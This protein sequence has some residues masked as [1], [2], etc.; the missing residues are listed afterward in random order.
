MKINF[1]TLTPKKKTIVLSI[2]ISLLSLMLLLGLA[3]ASGFDFKDCLQTEQKIVV[4]ENTNVSADESEL[5]ERCINKC[6]KLGNKL[7]VCKK[8]AK[9]YQERLPAN[10][11]ED[12]STLPEEDFLYGECLGAQLLISD[13]R[14]MDDASDVCDQ[15]CFEFQKESKALPLEAI[16]DRCKKLKKEIFQD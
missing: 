15:K 10:V 8:I 13:E 12:D 7:S 5:L 11:M 4:T 9:S 2:G 6:N 14:S 16:I 3:I 1:D